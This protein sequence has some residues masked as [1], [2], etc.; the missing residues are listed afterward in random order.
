VLQAVATLFVRFQGLTIHYQ[1]FHATRRS[2]NVLAVLHTANV[3]TALE[4]TRFDLAEKGEDFGGADL[5]DGT[6]KTASGICWLPG[7]DPNR[8]LNTL[9]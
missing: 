2:R 7:P 5:I 8:T 4:F 3:T 1:T 9:K 6:K